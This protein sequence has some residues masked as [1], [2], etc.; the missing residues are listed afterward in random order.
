ML[1]CKI[2][3]PVIQKS[4]ETH[5]M[6]LY[7]L[8]LARHVFTMHTELISGTDKNHEINDIQSELVALTR[9]KAV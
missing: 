2:V 6:D 8:H 9:D 7:D 4:T 5:V 3:R 1:V